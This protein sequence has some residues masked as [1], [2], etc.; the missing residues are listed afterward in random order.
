MCSKTNFVDQ[1]R[2][3]IHEAPLWINFSDPTILNL[4]NTEYMTEKPHL[5]FVSLDDQQ[6]D[7]WIWMVIYTQAKPDQGTSRKFVPAAHPI[8]LHGHDFAL[9]AQSNKSWE[10]EDPPTKYS[11]PGAKHDL[12]PD[13]LRC[14]NT[15]FIN[16]NNPPRRDSVLLP[17]G[18]YII[19]AFKAD[20]PGEPVS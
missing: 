15:E 5:D 1:Y 9:L 10:D 8:H 20:N 14:N 2:W 12:T 19:I 6:E 17:A 18:G 13:K 4:D 7:E 3:K 11:L 16:C